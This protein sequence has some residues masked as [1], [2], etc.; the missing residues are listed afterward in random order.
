MNG[1]THNLI[2]LLQTKLTMWLMNNKH[3]REIVLKLILSYYLTV[4]CKINYK[5]MNYNL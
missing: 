2:K 4:I 3:S 5:E 1:A